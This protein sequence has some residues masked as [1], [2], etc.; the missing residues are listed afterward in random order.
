MYALRIFVSYLE[1]PYLKLAHGFLA[2]IG[3]E[4]IDMPVHMME[5]GHV[6]PNYAGLCSVAIFS[7]L[8]NISTITSMLHVIQDFQLQVVLQTF[9]EQTI[10]GHNL[11]YWIIFVRASFTS[12]KSD[13]KMLL[14]RTI[15]L[16]KGIFFGKWRLSSLTHPSWEATGQSVS[17]NWLLL[18]RR[19]NRYHWHIC[20]SYCWHRAGEP[21]LSLA[22]YKLRRWDAI[23][24]ARFT[25][26]ANAF[27]S[28]YQSI[29]PIHS[30]KVIVLY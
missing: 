21:M 11:Q 14:W 27:F 29:L 24:P 23:S 22:C 19:P 20:A 9:E 17:K 8:N 6:F 16:C 28:W 7:S 12:N 10:R 15:M 25:R 1:A 4:R 3:T 13:F 26:L 5:N 2:L 30:S 18:P